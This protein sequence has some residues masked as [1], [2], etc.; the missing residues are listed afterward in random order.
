[1]LPPVSANGFENISFNETRNCDVVIVGSGP[2]GA[3]AARILSEKGYSV[4]VLE[5]GPKQSR[6]ASN[7]AHTAKYHMQ[8]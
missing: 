3:V 2:G 5:S 7:Y 4:I 1:M 6:F 8:Y